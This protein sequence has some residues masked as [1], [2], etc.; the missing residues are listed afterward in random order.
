MIKQNLNA[1]LGGL[2]LVMLLLASTKK[3]LSYLPY[4][5]NL[6]WSYCADE[7]YTEPSAQTIV[8][9][10]TVTFH[11]H[12][13]GS[14]TQLRSELPVGVDSLYNTADSLVTPVADG[15][16][17]DLRVD[18]K[19]QSTSNS[20]VMVLLLDIGGSQGVIV[21]RTLTF[22]KGANTDHTFSVG[23]PVFVG[24]TFL[25][26]GGKI[27]IWSANGNTKIWDQAILIK[28]DYHSR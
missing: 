19:A 1:V 2:A 28:K 25:A 16:G 26:N 27:R 12:G 3:P 22:P 13:G 17:Y 21:D 8:L 7:V 6:G 11:I 9:N 20:G 4:Q 15:D 5:N 14:G 23:F 24:S 10:D 18:F